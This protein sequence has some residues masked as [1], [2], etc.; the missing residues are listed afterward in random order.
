MWPPK[1]H[2]E[3]IVCILPRNLINSNYSQNNFDR[4]LQRRVIMGIRVSSLHHHQQV[5]W[6]YRKGGELGLVED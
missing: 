3:I 1:P 5:I 6:K 2:S 4:N